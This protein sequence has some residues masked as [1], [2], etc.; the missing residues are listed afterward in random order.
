MYWVAIGPGGSRVAANSTLQVV[1]S[2]FETG[3]NRD[4]WWFNSQLQKL[5]VG[6]EAEVIT[7]L[8]LQGFEFSQ[9]AIQSAFRML[10]P[11]YPGDVG[12]MP[13]VRAQ[14]DD[15][16]YDN[17]YGDEAVQ[18]IAQKQRE[19]KC[20]STLRDRSP[21]WFKSLMVMRQ[22]KSWKEQMNYTRQTQS[23]CSS[24]CVG[25]QNQMLSVP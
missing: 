22:R 12:M 1:Q 13:I 6:V 2:F 17:E 11:L 14:L 4:V 25:R 15:D 24:A 23:G 16:V 21:H 19:M 8:P 20:M 7:P 18:L 5:M 3:W 10:H 9:D